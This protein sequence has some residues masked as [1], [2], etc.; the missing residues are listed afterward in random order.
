[1]Q[2]P[3]LVPDNVELATNHTWY[4][5]NVDGTTTVGIDGLLSHV[6]GGIEGVLAPRIGQEVTPVLA[7][8]A[9]G[10]RGRSMKLSSALSGKVVDVN[11][12]IFENP[13]LVLSD[14]YGKG[15]LM[16]VRTSQRHR[17][18][19]GL[20]AVES[21]REWLRHQTALVRDFIAMHGSQGTPAMLQ[22]GGLPVQ[23]VLQQFDQRLWDE[24]SRSFVFLQS[25]QEVEEKGSSS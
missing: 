25:G 24:F 11:D 14:P 15:W 20:F 2:F 7:S 22:E 21:P 19:S 18:D 10:V 13:S 6:I 1:M 3:V 12:E 5:A 8:I 17:E 4:R 16:R 23:G 9:V